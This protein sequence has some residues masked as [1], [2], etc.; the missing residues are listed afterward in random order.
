MQGY[1]ERIQW[2]DWHVGVVVVVDD[3]VYNFVDPPFWH[4]MLI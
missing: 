1:N 4:L 3:D 2:M